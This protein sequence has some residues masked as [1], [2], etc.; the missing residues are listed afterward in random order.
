MLI[1]IMLGV[2]LDNVLMLSAPMLSVVMKGIVNDA[3]VIM[4]GV[5]APFFQ[6][7]PFSL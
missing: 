3:N 2:V 5:V 6:P 7:E 1:V 4:L